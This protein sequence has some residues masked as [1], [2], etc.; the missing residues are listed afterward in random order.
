M[1]NPAEESNPPK[2]FAQQMI[3]FVIRLKHEG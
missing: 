3:F 2:F 1:L